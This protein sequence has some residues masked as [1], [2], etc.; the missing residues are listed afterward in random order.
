[1]RLSEW[2]SPLDSKKRE[3]R[4]RESQVVCMRIGRSDV[5]RHWGFLYVLAERGQVD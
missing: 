2:V 5:L 1:M 3:Y 4:E